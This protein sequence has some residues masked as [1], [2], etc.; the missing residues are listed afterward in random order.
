MTTSLSPGRWVLTD[1][2]VAVAAA[3][4][5]GGPDGHPG[6]E[7]LDVVVELEDGRLPASLAAALRLLSTATRMLVATVARPGSG[8]VVTVSGLSEDRAGPFSL[9]SGLSDEAIQLELSPTDTTVL[10]TLD[11]LLD[12]TAFA[13]TELRT[14]PIE[15]SANGWMGLLAAADSL[16][17]AALTADLQRSG[18]LANVQVLSGSLRAEL[19]WG[20]STTDDRWAVTAAALVA[21]PPIDAASFDEEAAVVELTAAGLVEGSPAAFS[22]LGS[23]LAQMLGQLVTFGALDLNLVAGERRVPVGRLTTLVSPT[24]RWVG[25]W[26]AGAT[27]LRIRLYRANRALALRLLNDLITAPI[28]ADDPDLAAALAAE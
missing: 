18:P 1:E 6:A 7:L 22:A 9:R 10:V 3:L 27:G 4:A 23:E 13:E 17:E 15:L 19:D 20:L 11:H 26:L 24:D 8:E 28:N 2:Q 16:R 25:V 21:P 5:D 14:E 12:L